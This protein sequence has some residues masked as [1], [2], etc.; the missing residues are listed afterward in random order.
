MSY[1][2]TCLLLVL[3]LATACGGSDDP[4][5]PA[6]AQATT[7]D[8]EETEEPPNASV[9]YDYQVMERSRCEGTAALGKK[10]SIELVLKKGALL[11]TPFKP[12][13][14]TDVAG[15]AVKVTIL[16]NDDDLHN[17]I[18]EGN[19]FELRVAPGDKGSVKVELPDQPQIGF[20]CTIHPPMYGAFFR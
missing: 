18:V 19:D 16:N 7:P 10:S 20:Q 15:D 3:V 8:A 5:A 14:I 17:F 13:C 1:L 2:R 9:G 12:N 11:A 6:E 4:P